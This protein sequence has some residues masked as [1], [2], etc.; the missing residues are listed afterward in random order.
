MA[1]ALSVTARGATILR[2]TKI[3]GTSDSYSCT[4]VWA[5]A[6]FMV[7]G[8]RR[9]KLALW[10]TLEVNGNRSGFGSLQERLHDGQEM[11]PY[12]L[13]KQFYIFVSHHR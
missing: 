7:H 9:N 10:N 8:G 1:A 2:T 5:H 11:L 12:T 4:N 3:L 6:G 13:G